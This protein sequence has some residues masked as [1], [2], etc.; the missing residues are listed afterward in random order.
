MHCGNGS[1]K[2]LRVHA[3]YGVYPMGTPLPL[4]RRELILWSCNRRLCVSWKKN[5]IEVLFI[6]KT[7]NT[8]LQNH[9]LKGGEHD[10]SKSNTPIIFKLCTLIL[11]MLRCV[12]QGFLFSL[13][14]TRFINIILFKRKPFKKNLEKPPF[15]ARLNVYSPLDSLP[16]NSFSFK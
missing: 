7:L 15:F 16:T 8:S 6:L 13:I 10:I 9:I 12:T 3:V 2:C 11:Y 1:Q 4:R 5:V 14:R